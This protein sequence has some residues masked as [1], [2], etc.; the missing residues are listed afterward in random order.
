MPS[1]SVLFASPRQVIYNF[2]IFIEIL[3]SRRTDGSNI[4][5]RAHREFHRLRSRRRSLTPYGHA[6]LEHGGLRLRT[7]DVPLQPFVRGQH[8]RLGER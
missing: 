3:C 8:Y 4:S 6:F 5:T 1:E 7:L 2:D